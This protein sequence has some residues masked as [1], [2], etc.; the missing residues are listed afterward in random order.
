LLMSRSSIKNL[1]YYY[2]IFLVLIPVP[3]LTNDPYIIHILIISMY[4]SVLASSWNLLSGYTGLFCLS[5]HT[6]AGLAG[7]ISALLVIH[8]KIPMYLAFLIAIFSITIVGLLIGYITLRMRGIYLALTTWAFAEIVRIVIAAE[9]QITR[10]DLGL[11]V[12]PLFG[13]I[14]PDYRY[15]Y[16]WLI[17]L[18]TTYTIVLYIINSKYGLYLRAIKDDEIAARALGVNVEGVRTSIFA[19]SAFLSGLAGVFYAHYIGTLSPAIMNFT[20]M[21]IIIVSTLL[22]GWG[23]VIGPII[24]SFIIEIIS[25]AARLGS[26]LRLLVFSII[27]F[28][29]SIILKG[30]IID[31]F[32]RYI[33]IK[34]II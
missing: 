20:E 30:S 4:Y 5:T 15:Y 12:P 22:G 13:D 16:V 8:L 9:Y 29:V 21:G 18:L 23:S 3:L 19:L 26:G 1:P 17:V 34:I 24:G 31:I 6:F 10:G 32:K 33:R 25:E 28:V 11:Q 2:I 27:A 7:Y 14:I